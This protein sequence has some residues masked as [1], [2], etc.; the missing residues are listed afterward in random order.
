MTDEAKYKAVTEHL[1]QTIRAML[2]DMRR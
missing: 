1:K 2:D